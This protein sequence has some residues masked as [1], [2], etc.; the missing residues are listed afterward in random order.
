MLRKINIYR[1]E[2]YK[3]PVRISQLKLSSDKYK[4]KEADAL[5]RIRKEQKNKDILKLGTPR[6]ISDL[7]IV[8]LYYDNGICR[9]WDIDRCQQFFYPV[10]FEDANEIEPPLYLGFEFY[11]VGYVIYCY[12]PGQFQEENVGCYYWISHIVSHD[13]DSTILMTRERDDAKIWSTMN[14]LLEWCEL[15]IQNLEALKKNGWHFCI[16]DHNRMSEQERM[17]SYYRFH[18][19]K[20]REIDETKKRLAEILN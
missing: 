9:T 12:P 15:H 4:W 16:K 13:F 2:P 5:E 8:E 14:C 3:D 10:T 6:D 7:G 18:L 19:A 17:T 11:P 1:L 20:R